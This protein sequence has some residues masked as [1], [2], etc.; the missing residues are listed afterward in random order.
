MDAAER[1][2]CGFFACLF[3][4]LVYRFGSRVS[5]SFIVR[6]MLVYFHW[7]KILL[8]HPPPVSAGIYSRSPSENQLNMQPA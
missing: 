4:F 7:V 2:T 1:E 5:S 3:D 8:G 6:K